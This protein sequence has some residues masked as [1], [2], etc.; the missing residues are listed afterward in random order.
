MLNDF[1]NNYKFYNSFTSDTLSRKYCLNASS[2]ID[3]GLLEK[4]KDLSRIFFLTFVV[5][6]G[7]LENNR[8]RQND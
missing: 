8:R 1:H 5:Q 4:R 2:A 7:T 6:L 3:S